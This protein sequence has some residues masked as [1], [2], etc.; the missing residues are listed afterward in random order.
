MSVLTPMQCYAEQCVR[1]RL[2]RRPPTVQGAAWAIMRGM[3]RY[4]TNVI[5][6][7]LDGLPRFRLTA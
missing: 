5:S 3:E 7:R 1:R 6:R 2:D 4:P